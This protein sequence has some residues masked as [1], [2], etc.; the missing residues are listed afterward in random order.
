MS[1]YY[2][3]TEPDTGW[4]DSGD[5][6][7]P[8]EAPAPRTSHHRKGSTSRRHKRPTVTRKQAEAVLDRYE[9]LSAATD[10]ELRAVAAVLGTADED[11]RALTI[12][13]ASGASCRAMEDL[14][15]IA[16]HQDSDRDM[17][18]LTLAVG[19][20]GM[21]RLRAAWDLAQSLTGAQGA[22][23]S[24]PVQ[25]ARELAAAA[26]EVADVLGTVQ[27]LLG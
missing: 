22:L 18:A 6:G 21:K 27:S 16:A 11:A 25:A 23:P 10:P 2:T 20:S 19:Q 26:V 4:A 1:D 9:V 24:S 3:Q 13:T 17:A 7:R 8:P 15:E 12:A 14:L 5:A